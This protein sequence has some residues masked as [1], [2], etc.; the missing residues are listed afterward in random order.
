MVQRYKE[1]EKSEMY[2]VKR[3]P[4]WMV[5][6]IFYVLLILRFF[7]EEEK[8]VRIYLYRYLNSELKKLW[9]GWVFLFF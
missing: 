9:E 3:V 5:S 7:V 6:L 4:L 8:L 2:L 1:W